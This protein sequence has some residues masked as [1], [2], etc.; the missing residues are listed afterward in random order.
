MTSRHVCL[1]DRFRRHICPRVAGW[2]IAAQALP[3]VQVEARTPIASPPA[4]E[5]AWSSAASGTATA[6]WEAS[7]ALTDALSWGAPAASVSPE[8]APTVT[9]NRT[10]PAVT[11]PSPFVGFSSSPTDDEFFRGR[12]FAE[13]LVPLGR[14]TTRGENRALARA[15]HAYR[16][17]APEFTAPIDTF[18]RD[19]ADTPWRASLL[20]NLGGRLRDAGAYTRALA[21]W[22]AAWTLAE[23][24]TDPHGRAIADLAIAEWLML[25]ASLMRIDEVETRL[26]A[27]ATRDVRGSSG[28][29]I[30]QVRQRL[31]WWRDHP[32]EFV[33]AEARALERLVSFARKGESTAGVAAEAAA[34]GEAREA[35]EARE[36]AAPRV[37]VPKGKNGKRASV[38]RRL[39]WL[40]GPA[41]RL[42]LTLRA[43]R[44]GV[45]AS[46]AAGTLVPLKNG[47]VLAL[48]ESHGDRFTAFDAVLNRDLSIGRATLEEEASEYALMSRDDA[49]AAGWT[50]VAAVAL[51]VQSTLCPPGTPDY[52]EPCPCSGGGPAGMPAYSIHHSIAGLV[53]QD[54]PVTYSVPRG[55]AP[56]LSVS[57]GSRSTEDPAVFTFSNLGPKWRFDWRAYIQERPVG[58]WSGACI[59][60]EFRVVLR[61]G[62]FESYEPP[63]GAWTTLGPHFRSLAVIVRTSSSPR[64]YERRMPDGSKE[65]Y[66]VSEGTFD[67]ARLFLSDVVD[68][69]GLSV[70]LTYDAQFR[71]VS[72]TDAIGQVTTLSYEHASDPLKI[73]K[74]TDPF[75]RFATFTYNTAGQLA[76][77]TDAIGLTSTFEY[78]QNDFI[79][80]MNTPYGTTTF[81]ME[82]PLLSQ[83]I[84]LEATD[85]LGGTE[86]VEYW[87]KHPSLSATVPASE[88][89]TGFTAA[90]QN[91]DMFVTLY[92]DKLAMARQPRAV[93]SATVT[94]LLLR[95]GPD[96]LGGS[97]NT[98]IP[99]YVKRPLESRIWYQYP[100]QIPSVGS[101]SVGMG[102]Q[103]SVTAR[104]LDDGTSQIAERTY[105]AVGNVTQETS[106]AG[107]VTILN[108]YPNG[109]DLQEIRRVNGAGTDLLKSQTFNSQH[110]PL[111]STDAAGQTTTFTYDSHGQIATVTTPPRSGITEN[112]TKTY[113]FSTNGE[114]QSVSGPE[115]GQTTSFTYD[116]YARLKTATDAE[117]HT[118]T[119][120][121]D[122]FDRVIRTTYPD[123][124]YEE[125]IYNRLDAERTRDRLGRWTHRTYDG[126]RR[127][128]ATRDPLGRSVT[129]QWC[130]CG[131]LEKMIDGNGNAI[132]WERDLL[133]RVTR[134][135]RVDGSD[136][137]FVYETS[138]SR[139]KS[140]TDANNQT[141]TYE[142]FADDNLKQIT[143]TN[144]LNP[145]ATVS[146][147]YDASYNR[148]LTMVDGTGTTTYTYYP[149]TTP[150]TLGASLL[151]SVDGPLTND[152][153]T[154]TYDE[155]ARRTGQSIN[156]AATTMVYDVLGRVESRVTLIGTFN[157][158]YT[159]VT[160]RLSAT[161]YPNGQT[162]EYDYFGA[163]GDHRLED[164]HN[165]L[166]GG[167]TLSRFQYTY[168]P[169]SRIKTWTQQRSADP[170]QVYELGYDGANQLTS[171]TLKTTAVTPA[172]LKRF[173]YGF[174]NSGNRVTEQIDDSVMTSTYG[175]DRLLTQQP[176]GA[177]RFAGTVDEPATLT[178]QTKPAQVGSDNRFTGFATVPA[179]TSTVE[180]KATDTN[181]NVRTNNYE[182]TL[183]GASKSFSYDANGNLLG[184]G[185]RTF[186]WDAENRLLAVALGTHRS[187]FT[188]DGQGRR[189]RIVEKDNNVVTGERWFLWCDA[190]ICEERDNGGATV[191]KRF[192]DLGQQEDGVSYYYA[193]DHLGSVREMT[194]GS[195]TIRAR[196]DYDPY[197]RVTKTAGDKDAA[198]QFSGHYYHAPSSLVLT[199]AR[200][201]DSG[202]GRW[203]SQDPAGFVDGTNLYAYVNNDPVDY[204]DPLGLFKIVD[205]IKKIPTL[206]IYNVCPPTSGGA[207]VVDPFGYYVCTC[208]DTDCTTPESKVKLSEL[209]LQGTLYVYS[210]PFPLLPKKPKDKSVKDK[211]SAIAHEYDVHIN[212]AIEAVR[213]IIEA[214]ESKTFPSKASC[215]SE[216]SA[217]RG[218][219]VKV[220]GETLAKTQQQENNSK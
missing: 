15:L 72:L 208:T 51:P 28:N 186:E 219:V 46:F 161:A 98:S 88:V 11:P 196:Y 101:Q 143:Y 122:A 139:V 117:G 32:E 39:G 99:S 146:F 25:S 19:H 137:D 13:P 158:D 7:A 75:G 66:S 204:L 155:L 185:A 100:N 198:F 191:R 20:V 142:Y 78:G 92:W 216:C 190:N 127:V 148:R 31:A 65:I 86:R 206:G 3:L 149:V 90:N 50:E 124:T 181:G 141:A 126:L 153:I 68:P 24:A 160:P 172:I 110:R 44:R 114:L 113:T 74:I 2:L 134:E 200:A 23:R 41:K 22:D 184:D 56:V 213:P 27:I 82:D 209:R 136:I 197:G 83:R 26:E 64:T 183:A 157:Y 40:I 132:T 164:I 151:A 133:G 165:K 9:V 194:D 203:I 47:H 36:A 94:K 112:R 125:T 52:H 135:I 34:A 205:N 85:P 131:A 81:R 73:T 63:L 106:A 30:A 4:S 182:M 218:K 171:A 180:V 210:G 8:A 217:T 138:T 107:R 211:A 111:T 37:T 84:Y 104:V 35:R 108:Y 33:P 70:H 169:T 145:T 120:D 192:F 59:D 69:Q 168:D 115:A 128:V 177:L 55:P 179:G 61:G 121:Y 109:I 96:Y 62:G 173:A 202:I 170:A 103:P 58:C 60:P 49:S 156:G 140:V 195:A 6:L 147:T 17:G 123:G 116:T 43:K 174:D 71:I 150:A 5:S 45:G 48:L 76:S 57:Y 1:F 130:S 166:S 79:M 87:G 80:G 175:M 163:T 189:V 91:M 14:A 53:V 178:V 18:L 215:Q 102:M 188:Y 214:F 16:Q 176:G 105:N 29:R 152:T 77:I 95:S 207:C 67:G 93:A 159:G 193:K 201:Y 89:P 220:F 54:T 144:A 38:S 118:T 199:F 97:P 167:A 162:T 21:A 212:P 187:E 42:G 10:V 119:Y 154:Y 129:Q 12:V